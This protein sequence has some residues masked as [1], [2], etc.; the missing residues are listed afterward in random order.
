MSAIALAILIASNDP[1]AAARGHQSRGKNSGK[2]TVTESRGQQSGGKS[3]AKASREVRRSDGGRSQA[4]SANVQK[5]SNVQRRSEVQ[6]QQKPAARNRVSTPKQ[7]A[8][9]RERAQVEQN[10]VDRAPSRSQV[11]SNRRA[12]R[13]S[14]SSQR[15][16]RAPTKSH[17]R[18]QV[19]RAPT[20]SHA[21]TQVESP[22]KSERREVTPRHPRSNER[23]EQVQ[24]EWL[25]SQREVVRNHADRSRERSYDRGDVDH[26]S[27]GGKSYRSGYD[28]N[29]YN[30][31]KYDARWRSYDTVH[32]GHPRKVH[33]VEQWCSNA[34]ARWASD[35][36]VVGAPAYQCYRPV[37][38]VPSRVVY[39][40]ERP[41]YN[42]VN[43]GV[44]FPRFWIDFALTD[45]APYGYMYY[46]PYC[47]DFFPTV[48]AYHSHLHYYS[49]YPA[50]DVVYVDD[51][52]YDPVYV[53]RV[54]SPYWHVEIGGTF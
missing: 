22:R 27:Y 8:P 39:W 7:T 20:K 16:E 54:N 40:H 24:D 19:E 51:I 45:T 47:D 42:Y 31:G 32:R 5:R 50:L 41:Y 1:A 3:T 18:T 53:A 37:R 48:T 2:A 43:L 36:Y 52:A 13:S 38:Y 44:Y 29:H 46:D 17:A 25:G 35:I 49:H 4:P 21:R 9:R 6:R 33:H 34:Q 15:V 10:R 26:R 30:G 14:S 11:E 28:T 12:S 23:R